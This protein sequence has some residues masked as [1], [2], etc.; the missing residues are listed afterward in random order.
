LRIVAV[1]VVLLAQLGVVAA[2]LAFRL[3]ATPDWRVGWEQVSGPEKSKV[4]FVA[5]AY[6]V[7]A[8]IFSP[9]VVDALD[10]G[11]TRNAAIFLIAVVSMA[12]LVINGIHRGVR[13]LGDRSS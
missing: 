6:P 13:A 4:I 9:I 5:I 3:V 12:A 2:Y 7:V 8:A 1:A 11:D 10:R